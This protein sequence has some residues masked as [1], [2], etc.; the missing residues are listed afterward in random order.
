LILHGPN[1]NLLG[2][3]EKEIYGIYT[4]EDLDAMI[5]REAE[6]LGITVDCHQSNHE[7]TLIDL[8]HGAE[9]KYEGIIFNPGAFTHYSIALRDALAAVSVPA[10]E[11]HLSNIY[12]REELRRRSVIAPV[13]RGQISGLGPR[14]YLLALYALASEDS[15][16]CPPGGGGYGFERAGARSPELNVRG[17][18]GAIDAASNDEGEI[19]AATAELLR[20]IV[21]DNAVAKE[22]VA[23][24]IFSLTPDLNAAFPAK[25]A[26]RMGWTDVPLFCSVEIGVTGALPRCIRVLMLVNTSMKPREIKHVYL[27]GAAVLREDLEAAAAD[28]S[29]V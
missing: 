25:A 9:G 19:L 11:V 14:S 16:F 6:K 27:K 4:L 1:L 29:G 7:G 23:A 18:R 5:R 26:R 17:I 3:R 8:I 2:K 21:T 10:V 24:V 28:P 13:A 12:A 20:Q 22:N 15:S